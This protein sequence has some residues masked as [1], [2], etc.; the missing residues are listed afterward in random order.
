MQ[1][2]PDLGDLA[3]AAAEQDGN[4]LADQPDFIRQAAAGLSALEI[5]VLTSDPG[6]MR[7]AADDK[8][9]TIVTL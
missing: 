6:D 4:P 3:I 1:S 2:R 8:R 5:V 9:V 7:R